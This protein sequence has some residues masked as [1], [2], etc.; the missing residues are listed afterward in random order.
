MVFFEHSGSEHCG[1]CNYFSWFNDVGIEE[2]GCGSTV[3]I[4]ERGCGSI[5]NEEKG[6]GSVKIEER[7]GGI[8]KN[9]ARDGGI[10]NSQQM[11]RSCLMVE[12]L[13]ADRNK[14]FDLEKCIKSFEKR[15]KVLT[16]V[17]CVVCVLNI[18]NV[19]DQ[20]LEDEL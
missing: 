17:V 19:V 8:V 3:K 20:K 2:R 15:I 11:G 10:V 14:I 6:G 7:G 18:V 1:G 5:K 9:E 12:E 4:E 16:R 13:V